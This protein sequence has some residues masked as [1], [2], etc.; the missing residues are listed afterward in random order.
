MN[1]TLVFAIFDFDRFSKHD[2]IGEVK[3]P[4]CQIDLAQTIE[5]WRELQSVE[6]EG[7]QVRWSSSFL[8]LLS[9]FSIPPKPP[10]FTEKKTKKVFFS[11]QTKPPLAISPLCSEY[12]TDNCHRNIF[13]L[14]SNFSFLT[15]SKRKTFRCE[16]VGSA[17][18]ILS[19]PIWS[20]FASFLVWFY[21]FYD[22]NAKRTKRITKFFHYLIEGII[23]SGRNARRLFLL[24]LTF[25]AL[26]L[27]AI[28]IA[29]T[30]PNQ[31]STPQILEKRAKRL[32][33]H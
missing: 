10:N 6:G 16:A 4:L 20:S 15:F 30:N 8:P 28:S 12:E 24:I 26:K 11:P 5:E 3:V 32:W 22:F 19:G 21:R 13:K 18:R 1:K 27:I 29:H 9:L 23:V 25:Y 2:Q 7:G 31:P 33:T 14:K 17:S